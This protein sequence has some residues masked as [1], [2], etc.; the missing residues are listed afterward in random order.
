MLLSLP[1]DT[2]MFQFSGFASLTYV[3][4]QGSSRLT[5]WGFPIR[6]STGKLASSKPWL[7]AGS[8]V[9]RRLSV[10]RHPPHALNNLVK[11]TDLSILNEYQEI[12]L[13]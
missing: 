4:S 10:P 7:I 9:L 8:Y 3:F 2:K 6:K 11:K 13:I 12:F 1:P 5:Q